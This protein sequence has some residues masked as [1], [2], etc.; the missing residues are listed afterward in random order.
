MTFKLAADKVPTTEVVVPTLVIKGNKLV[1]PI[2]GSLAWIVDTELQ[3]N[4]T[5]TPLINSS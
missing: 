5:V 1:R 4:N 3:Q 2:I